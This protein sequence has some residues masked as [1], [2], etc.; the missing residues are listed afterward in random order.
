MSSF[1]FWRKWAVWVIGGM[2]RR[3]CRSEQAAGLRLG[4]WDIS[5]TLRGT[6]GKHLNH[7]HPFRPFKSCG[8][9]WAGGYVGVSRRLCWWPM[10]LLCHPQSQLDFG[11]LTA[12]GLGLGLGL[13]GLDLGLGLD[14]YSKRREMRHRYRD[15][16]FSCWPYAWILYSILLPWLG[17]FKY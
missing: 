15:V 6:R 10:W 8:V 2:S 14:N 12:L 17:V 13:G 11:F 4:T 7:L 9:E 1:N 3:L 5:P 16:F